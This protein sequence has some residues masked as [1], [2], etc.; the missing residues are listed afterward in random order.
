[1]L[2]A[3]ATTTKAEKAAGFY[4][5]LLVGVRAGWRPAAKTDQVVAMR[6]RSGLIHRS[7]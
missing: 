6:L 4:G 7:L 1:M 5:L 3:R 2:T